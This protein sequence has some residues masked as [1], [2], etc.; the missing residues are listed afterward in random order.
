MKQK[1]FIQGDQVFAVIGTASILGKVAR[2]QEIPYDKMSSVRVLLYIKIYSTEVH[3]AAIYRFA[4]T[5]IHRKSFESVRQRMLFE[6]F[7]T[8]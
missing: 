3:L 5:P 2:N 4:V 7:E 8:E 6:V 1:Q